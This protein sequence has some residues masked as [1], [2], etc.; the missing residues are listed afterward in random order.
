MSRSWTRPA[1]LALALGV[2][3]A[4]AWSNTAAIAAAAPLTP[5]QVTE[6]YIRVALAMDVEAAKR[7]NDYLRPEFDGE[8]AL[9]LEQMGSA[10]ARIAEQHGQIADALLRSTPQVDAGR[11][12]PVVVDS[13]RLQ[14]RAMAQA[15]C[16]GVSHQQRP[17]TASDG[18]VA[19]VGYECA[20][21]A[22]GQA[23]Q[24]AFPTEALDKA[25]TAS[26]LQ[27][28]DQA[29]TA[30]EQAPEQTVEGTMTLYADGKGG[31]WHTGSFTDVIDVV[32]QAIAGT[33]PQE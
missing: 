4:P 30:F 3:A 31:P 9:D 6:L 20:V 25:T 8:D 32:H 13:L 18:V 16:R 1:V 12:K 7:L 23:L 17:N 19:E 29:A 11:L 10:Q 21:R 28:F 27:A 24:K 14:S 22:P 26:L 5:E 15:R 33:S 2:F